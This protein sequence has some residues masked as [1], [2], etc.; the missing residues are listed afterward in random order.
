[1]NIEGLDYNTK[2]NTLLLPE[3]G[4]EIQRMVEYALTITDCGERQRC[5]EKIV[6]TMQQVSPQMNK[7][8]EAQHKYWDHLA[9]MSGFK[10]DVTY[11]YDIEHAKKISEKPD[12]VTY[13]RQKDVCHYGALLFEVFEKLKTMPEGK[14]RDTLAR[15]IAQA[16]YHC[17]KE[18]SQTSADAAR[19]ASDLAHFT[20]GVVQIDP[21]TLMFT[22]LRQSQR[23]TDKKKKKK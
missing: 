11:P 2:R 13:S 5:A 7:E 9:V 10:L 14:E 15:R 19:V 8:K 16:M 23:A 6:K 4:R 22:A 12:R 17:L 21:D 3:Y 18:F 20:D 1:M